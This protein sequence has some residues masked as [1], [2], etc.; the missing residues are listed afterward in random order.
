MIKLRSIC[1]SFG[2]DRVLNNVSFK[3]TPGDRACLIGP[4]GS[5]KT[6]ILKILLGL[7]TP[8]SGDAFLLDVNMAKARESEKQANLKKIG[9]AFQ[10]GAL[11]DYM[12]VEENIRFAINNM[13]DF[14]EA[15]AREKVNKL[16]ATVKLP[17]TKTMFPYELSGGMKR[18]VGII[19]AMATEPK[20]AIFDEP[21]SGLDPVTSTIILNMI[22][23]MSEEEDG[24][25]LLVC[26]S[27]V[28]V[29]LRFAKRLIVVNQQGEVE[30]DGDWRDLLVS[31]SEWVKKFLGIRLIGIDLGYAKELGLPQEFIDEHW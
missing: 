6:T 30:A 11:F 22:S 15:K 20:I 14:S 18:R 25:T 9:M 12:T 28:E 29:A 27:S 10:Q 5:G 31:G 1:K 24:M 2:S 4:G 3:I 8:D 23:K 16:L 19:R 17:N 7:E 26:T 21:T 13:T